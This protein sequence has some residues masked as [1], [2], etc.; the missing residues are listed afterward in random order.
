MVEFHDISLDDKE[1][2]LKFLS[3]CKQIPSN[4]SPVISLGYREIFQIKC[5]CSDNIFWSKMFID[6]Q[7][8]W[9]TPAGDWD[10]IDWKNV[11]EKN[12]PDNTIFAFIPEYLV[13][14]WQNQIGENIFVEEQRDYWDY[15]LSTKE[16][17]E[18]QGGKFKKFRRLKNFFEENYKFEIEEI[19]PKIFD[20][21][22]E[23]QNYAEKDVQERVE[24]HLIDAQED[25]NNFK[26]ALEIWDKFSEKLFGFVIRVENKI[27]AY[28]V[29]EILNKNFLIGLFAKADYNFKGA[30]Q[31]AYWYDAKISLERG[32]NFTNIMD[33]AGEENLRFFKEHLN[34]CE[35]LKKFMVIYNP[36]EED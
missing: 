19:T 11:F 4:A 2:Y 10:K 16:I 28:S 27:V 22:L 8:L 31:F 36:S 15:I 29:D 1:T 20:E 26:L 34:P 7:E 17:F 21:L 23:F 32:I 35:M 12:V 25:D 30:N 13:N 14:L 9:A 24:N 5:A 6:N 3:Q 33:D 18:M